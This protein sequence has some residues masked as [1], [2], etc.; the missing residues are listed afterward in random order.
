[1]TKETYTVIDGPAR[2]LNDNADGMHAYSDETALLQY[3][4][5]KW[6]YDYVVDNND[7]NDGSWSDWSSAHHI[8]DRY[9]I[10]IEDTDGIIYDRYLTVNELGQRGADIL[11][12]AIA[13]ADEDTILDM[14]S[15]WSDDIS[16]DAN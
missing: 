14:F 10:L 1:M 12:A 7:N 16:D 4:A 11:N 13:G 15:D 2:I 9:A 6:L 8:R 5:T 3:D